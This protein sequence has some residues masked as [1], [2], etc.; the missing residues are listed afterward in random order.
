MRR[1][2]NRGTERGIKEGNKKERRKEVG[3]KEG[4]RMR[5]N[6]YVKKEGSRS[7]WV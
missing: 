1:K 6:V 4:G 5:T 3:K 7:K 2:G